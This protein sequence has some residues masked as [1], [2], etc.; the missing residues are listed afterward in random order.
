M[1]NL[2]DNAVKYSP[3]GG[4]VTVEVAIAGSQLR[5]AVRDAARHRTRTVPAIAAV[6]G[7][8]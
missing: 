8:A 7:S 2:V 1:T 6:A 3:D 5:Y 4:K